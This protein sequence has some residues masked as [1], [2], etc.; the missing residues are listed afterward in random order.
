MAPDQLLVPYQVHG[1]D[2]VSVEGQDED[3]CK[4]A[5]VACEERHYR[6][7]KE[8]KFLRGQCKSFEGGSVLL[9]LA[10]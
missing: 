6:I 10:W 2:S 1:C 3:T 8:N 9:C 5:P 4:A 7:K